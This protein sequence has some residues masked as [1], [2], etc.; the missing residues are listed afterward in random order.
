[1]PIYMIYSLPKPI[2]V[3]L[4]LESVASIANVVEMVCYYNF[5]AHVDRPAHKFLDAR[6]H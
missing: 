4:Q 2:K 6:F 5:V 3:N 1:M